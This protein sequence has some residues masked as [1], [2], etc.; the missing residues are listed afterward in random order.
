MLNELTVEWLKEKR[1]ANQKF[2]FVI[3]VIF[4]F[5]SFFMTLLM[6]ENPIN[7][8]YL[9][10]TGFNWYPTMI[11]PVVLSLLVGNIL[12]KEKEIN[13]I[14]YRS[15]GRNPW[16]QI[17]AKN[18]VVLFEVMIILII[19]SILFFLV[20]RF[21]LKEYI[22]GIEIIEATLTLFIGCLP[23]IGLSFVLNQFFPRVVTVLVNFLCGIC[24]AIF[25]ITPI[26]WLFPWDYMLRML[27]PV[28]G[29]HPNGTFLSENDSLRNPQIVGVGIIVSLVVYLL[30]F[31]IQLLV[32]RKKLN[33]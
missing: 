4:V 15:L 23:I 26:W 29:I 20:G 11:L 3:P 7:K 22:V 14:F 28:L 2:L 5:F 9:V 13:Q 24:A 18:I 25:A 12:T 10:A 1:T 21:I 19:S 16:L 33:G 32:E 31:L 17:I 30:I 8:S 6:G 27:C